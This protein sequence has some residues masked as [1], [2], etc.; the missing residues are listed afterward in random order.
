[1]GMLF[2]V[3]TADGS[4]THSSAR[5]HARSVGFSYALP[6]PSGRPGTWAPPIAEVSAC[7]A[8]YHLTR[9][10]LPFYSD[11]GRVFLAEARGPV[12]CD[13]DKVA[14][15]S[16]RLTLELDETWDLLPLFPEVRCFLMRRW[17]DAN[18]PDAQWPEWANL[19]GANLRDANLSGAKDVPDFTMPDGLLFSEYLRD[20]V[21]ALLTAGGK[22]IKE[23]INGGAW[24]CHSWDN[25]PMAM[26]F[27]VHRVE[28]VPPLYRA[29]AQEFVR[30]FDARMIP[31]PVIESE[32]AA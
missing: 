29:R 3:L 12:D 9:N 22:T 24:D 23:I 18:G 11:G 14:C 17:R 8:G 10:P 20:V 30:F 31:A 32:S 13:G 15:G 6:S 1:M 16:V 21:P 2:K 27:G 7:V 25:C 5:T 4:P 19:S 26:A 28:D